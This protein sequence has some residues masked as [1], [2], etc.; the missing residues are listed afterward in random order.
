MKRKPDILVILAT[1]LGLGMIFSSVSSVN[2]DNFDA[3]KPPLSKI[4]HLN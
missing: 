3:Q 1:L 4:H 2:A